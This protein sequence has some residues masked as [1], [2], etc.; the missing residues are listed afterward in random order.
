MK[1]GEEKEREQG[2]KVEN[3]EFKN[4]P[5]T[6]HYSASRVNITACKQIR[7]LKQIKM[8]IVS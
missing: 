4:S 7:E 3:T 8:N 6:H 5:V 1:E 2:K